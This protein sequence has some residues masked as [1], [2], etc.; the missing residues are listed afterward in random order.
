MRYRPLGMQE[1][2]KLEFERIKQPTLQEMLIQ[3]IIGKIMTGELKPG[4]HLPSEGNLASQLGVSKNIV[5]L[6]LEKLAQMG[7]VTVKPRS[8][9]YV[10]D[11]L[12]TGNFETL[13]AIIRY[14]NG[15]Y[16]TK[17]EIDMVDARNMIERGAL[18]R[19]AAK[20]TDADLQQLR[21]LN[22]LLRKRSEEG[23]SKEEL[24]TINR[25]FHLRI[26]ELS[27]SFIYSLLMNSF[28][29][30]ADLLWY[31]CISFWDADRLYQENRTTIALL[32][33]G[34]GDRAADLIEKLFAEYMKAHDMHRN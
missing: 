5:H 14:A 11:Y 3:Q 34:E 13:Q 16:D 12:K 2:E 21:D 28:G 20:H 8:G 31:R 6:G 24:S 33:K 7:F 19:V 23:A 30:A 22:E 9:S 15:Q 10:S 26:T 17:M 29:Q 27:D 4:D 25:D 32:E 1:G 18:R